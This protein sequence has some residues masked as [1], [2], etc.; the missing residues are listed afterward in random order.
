[1]SAADQENHGLRIGAIWGVPVHIGSSWL[2]LAV[3][4]IAITGQ[5]LS[6]LGSTAYVIG[7]LYVVALLIAV[8]VHEAAH[9]VTG[10]LLGLRVHRI[11]ADLWG[12]HTSYDAEGTT[13]RS[14]AL[15]ALAGPA[16]N[17]VLGMIAYAARPSFSG[18]VPELLLW[19][20]AWTNLLLA[21]FNLL[22]GLPLDGGQLVESAVW[23]ITGRRDRGLVVAGWSGR[24]VALLVVL[25]ILV[26]PML[27]GARPSLTSV[28]WVLLVAG[29]MWS[30]ATGAI[31]H[32]RARQT[33]ARVVVRDIA[34]SAVELPSSTPLAE[35]LAAQHVVISRDEHDRPTLVLVRPEGELPP[36]HVPLSAVLTRLPDSAVVEVSP[37]ADITRV[38]QAMNS[39][40]SGICI[41]TA[42]GAPYAV[43]DAASVN[44]AL[45]P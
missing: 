12:G 33:L 11:V 3:A 42:D 35:A 6:S 13:P 38:V 9:A 36:G 24:V 19:G 18:N 30:G 14:S 7:A 21:G 15:V 41:L 5:S 4:I 43:A 23:A 39:S 16:A 2:I 1:M 8:L 37:D 25:W 28:V 27:A 22:P 29:F 20:I 44:R 34:H 31:R 10:R 40:G 32:G 26:R 45:Q 17:L